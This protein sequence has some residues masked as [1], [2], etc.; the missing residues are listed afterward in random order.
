MLLDSLIRDCL[1]VSSYI[2]MMSSWLNVLSRIRGAQMNP[3]PLNRAYHALLHPSCGANHVLPVLLSEH[4][5]HLSRTFGFGTQYNTVSFHS[6]GESHLDV[7]FENPYAS[8]QKH[9]AVY[10]RKTCVGYQKYSFIKCYG[11]TK[12]TIQRITKFI[13]VNGGY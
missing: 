11:D 6:V 9:A 2:W 12:K 1:G 8:P 5:L 10:G 3:V 7:S 13:R 4:P